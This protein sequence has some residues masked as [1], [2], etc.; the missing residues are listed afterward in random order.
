M[1][2][3]VGDQKRAN[4]MTPDPLNLTYRIDLS[5]GRGTRPPTS[6]ETRS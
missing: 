6:Y 2:D 4:L 5:A 3:Q 1:G